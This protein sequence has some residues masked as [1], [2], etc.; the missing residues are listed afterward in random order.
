MSV[1]LA[2]ANQ[3][4]DARET[5]WQRIVHIRVTVDALA[6]SVTALPVTPERARTL[7]RLLA[8]PGGVVA[9]PSDYEGML[10]LLIHPADWADLLRDTT[11]I[12]S[13]KLGEPTRVM[14]IPVSQ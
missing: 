10:E 6:G 5:G 4:N 11:A 12:R 1:E 7:G 2:I 9:D 13:V 3:L 8:V 14:G